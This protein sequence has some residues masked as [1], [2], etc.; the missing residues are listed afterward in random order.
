MPHLIRKLEGARQVLLDRI[1]ADAEIL[2]QSLD[3]ARILGDPD[4]LEA[5]SLEF[6]EQHM[7][8]ITAGI[9]AG[10]AF[11]KAVIDAKNGRD[12]GNS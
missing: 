4:Y 9:L 7:A 12:H 11:A 10:E 2:L 1:A 8:E 5:I 3:L 6:V